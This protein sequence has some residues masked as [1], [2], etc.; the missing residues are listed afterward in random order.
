MAAGKFLLRVFLGGFCNLRTDLAGE[1]LLQL[2][3]RWVPFAVK[4]IHLAFSVF[5][6]NTVAQ[7]IVAEQQTVTGNIGAKLDNGIA[8]RSEIVR[9]FFGSPRKCSRR[10]IHC[11]PLNISQPLQKLPLSS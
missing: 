5:R 10:I 9:R 11:P 8:K 2:P 7:M 3:R 1:M 6:P 4:A